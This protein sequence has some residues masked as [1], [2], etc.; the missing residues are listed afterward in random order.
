MMGSAWRYI[1]DV[2][3]IVCGITGIA[4]ALTLLRP[5]ERVTRRWI[6]YGLAWFACGILTVRG[7]AGLVA[8][9]WSDLVWSPSFVLGGMLFGGVA[10]FAN[11]GSRVQRKA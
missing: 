3:V 4:V 11:A 9:G 2:V 8:D 7:V 5:P 10:W 1:Y 6:P